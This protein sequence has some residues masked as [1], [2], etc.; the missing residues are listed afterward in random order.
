M[1]TTMSMGDRKAHLA[2]LRVARIAKRRERREERQLLH[3]ISSMSIDPAQRIDKKPDVLRPK[4]NK[5]MKVKGPSKKA[6]RNARKREAKRLEQAAEVTPTMPKA[7][8]IDTNVNESAGQGALSH[9]PSSIQLRPLRPETRAALQEFQ[10]LKSARNKAARAA[11][12]L[13]RAEQEA[14]SGHGNTEGATTATVPSEPLA[15]NAFDEENL[16]EA[17]QEEKMFDEATQS[18]GEMKLGRVRRSKAE[19]MSLPEVNEDTQ[20]VRTLRSGRLR[21]SYEEVASQAEGHRHNG[22][23]HGGCKPM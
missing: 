14:N 12:A 7:M 21:P 22:Q 5:A 3:K 2:A 18:L 16:Y 11:K 1:D 20:A 17:A 4:K 13:R 19:A 8:R 9:T 6:R 10:A 15:M 23:G